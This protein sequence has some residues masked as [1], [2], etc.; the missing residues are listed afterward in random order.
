M[1]GGFPLFLALLIVLGAFALV[2][3]MFLI[4]TYGAGV[5]VRRWEKFTKENGLDFENDIKD[6]VGRY[7]NHITFF[8]RGKTRSFCG[9]LKKDVNEETVY[10][11]DY[12]YTTGSLRNRHSHFFTVVLIEGPRCTFPHFFARKQRFLTDSIRKFWQEQD[13][14]YSEDREF[15]KSLFLRGADEQKTREFFNQQQ[16]RSVLSDC[17]A[18][19]NVEIETCDGAVVF[20]FSSPRGLKHYFKHTKT[21]LQVF[22]MFRVRS[23]QQEV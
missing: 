13:I 23:E 10:F 1:G 11:I 3:L 16:I 12:Y 17:I 4:I 14:S 21:A 19:N 15:S 2:G 5:S 8:R 22:E 7:S 9:A 20:A 18:T 6:V